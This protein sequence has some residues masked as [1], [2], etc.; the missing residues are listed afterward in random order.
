MHFSNSCHVADRSAWL[1][2]HKHCSI[3]DLRLSELMPLKETGGGQPIPDIQA[4]L[5]EA[6]TLP[7][8]HQQKFQRLPSSGRGAWSFH[9]NRAMRGSA[10]KTCCMQNQLMIARCCS[11]HHDQMHKFKSVECVG[12]TINSRR[13]MARYCCCASNSKVMACHRVCLQYGE[14]EVGCNLASKAEASRQSLEATA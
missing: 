3:A 7:L 4:G 9:V 5:G 11:A 14:L 8:Q 12:H 1:P 10:S 6:A 13:I 2:K